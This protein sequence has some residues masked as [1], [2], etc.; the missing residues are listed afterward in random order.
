MGFAVGQLV[1]E[2]GW[3]DDADEDLRS[4]IMD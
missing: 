1:Q 4:A 3:D 2:L